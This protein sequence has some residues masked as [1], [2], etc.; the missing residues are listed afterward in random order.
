MW[1]TVYARKFKEDIFFR[2]EAT[3]IALQIIYALIILAVVTGSLLVLYHEIVGGIAAAIAASLTTHTGVS[4]QAIV[5][6]LEETRTREVVGSMVLVLLT[7][8]GFGYL[9]A[10]QALMPARTALAS[11]KQFI[12]NMAH[13]LRTPL[14]VIKTNTQ[15]R[16]LE[17]D[18]PEASKVLLASTL[19]ELDRI[20]TIINNLLT[21]NS[22]VRPSELAR[23][24][25]ALTSVLNAVLPRITPLATKHEVRLDTSIEEPAMVYGNQTALEHIFMHVLK[26]AITYS[27]RGSV[28]VEIAPAPTGEVVCRF[29]DSGTGVPPQDLE[30]VFEPFFRVDRARARTEGRGAGL[31]LAIVRELV[32]VH[33]GRIHIESTLTVGTVVTIYL[34]KP[35]R[36]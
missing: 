17:A 6:E 9:I 27:S 23:G 29:I 19:E 18:V 31:G 22:S 26:N 13:E 14:A 8:C 30:H 15:V 1:A 11:Q 2:T 34:P 24:P 16:L 28:R 33:N 12:S 25:V 32:T 20:S 5:Q 36:S 10:R 35:A 7:A 21:L 4:P 3:I